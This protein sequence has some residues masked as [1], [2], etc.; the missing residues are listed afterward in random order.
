MFAST[1]SILGNIFYA[2]ALPCNSLTL[3]MIGRLLNGFGSARSINRRYIADTCSPRERTAASANFVTAGALGMA[4]GPAI[5]SLLHIGSPDNDFREGTIHKHIEETIYENNEE[6]FSIVTDDDKVLFNNTNAYWT[7]ENAPGW[8]MLVAWSIYLV[9]LCM[10]FDDPPKHVEPTKKISKDVEL[11]NVTGEMRALLTTE[12]Q[13]SNSDDDE[14]DDGE[15]EIPLWRN[16]PVMTT[17]F[18]YFVLKL[19]LECLLSSTSTLTSFYFDWDS[20][21]NGI[22]LAVLGLLMLPA[23]LGVAFLARRYDDRELILA[24]QI[25][26]LLGCCGIIQFTATKEGYSAI[27]YILFSVVIFLSTN[28]MEGPNMSLLSKTIPKSWSQGIFNVGLLATEAGTLGRAVGDLLL[29]AWGFKGL[30]TLLN[31]TFRSMSIWSCISLAL[32]LYF[33]EHLEPFEK[34]L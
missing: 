3:V 31:L 25:I 10:H 24:C 22:Y 28:A 26:M 2:I 21:V 1:C 5:A 19:V 12:T 9:F 23:N 20:S 6:P 15:G 16:I 32:T 14:D 11:A 27:Q 29:S 18:V 34:D 13:D 17:F 7:P 8:F 33:F 30:G 4:A